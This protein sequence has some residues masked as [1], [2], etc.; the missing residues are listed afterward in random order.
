MMPDVPPS[1]FFQEPPSKKTREN[2]FQN[3]VTH[4]ALPLAIQ[5]EY[6]HCGKT[7]GWHRHVNFLALYSVRRG[8]AMH[9]IND[10]PYGLTRGDIYLMPLGA[11]HR[12]CN[13]SGLEIDAFY[14]PA[15]FFQARELK[16]LRDW[17]DLWRFFIGEKSEGQRVH[18]TP[19]EWNETEK[20]I[21]RI[22]RD[23][24][25]C[26]PADNLMVKHDLF[27][28]LVVLA[29]R[30]DQKHLGAGHQNSTRPVVAQAVRWCEDNLDKTLTVSQM[31][32]RFFLSTG[33]FNELFRREVGVPP[34]TY[35]R[36]IRVEKA[37]HLL[38]TTDLTMMQ[39]ATQ[40]GFSDPAHFS[41]TFRTHYE[42]SPLQFRKRNATHST[43]KK[44][45]G[46][47]E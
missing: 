25:Q 20:Q 6:F 35:L 31:A 10:I 28:F 19:E 3:L 29:R 23:W 44:F 18:L 7:T 14:F 21:E 43:S 37:C 32:A 34:A 40:C 46:W 24:S 8:S 1:V 5:R 27:R 15:N 41:R 39:I 2:Y 12:Y 30:L 36:N 16:A 17:P 11:K 45:A 13:F 26:S 47:E 4:P 22:S 9:W 42:M 38:R 33:H